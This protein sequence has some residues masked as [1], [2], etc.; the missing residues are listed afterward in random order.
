MPPIPPAPIS[1]PC[2]TTR[3]P[4]RGWHRV[5]PDMQGGNALQQDH[6]ASFVLLL[7]ACSTLEMLFAEL[8]LEGESGR[9]AG[10]WHPRGAHGTRQV[11]SYWASGQGLAGLLLLG[12]NL[13]PSHLFSF[14]LESRAADNAVAA[15][16]FKG[17]RPDKQ[18]GLPGISAA[19]LSQGGKAPGALE[20]AV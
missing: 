20:Q 15:P 14:A 9:A 11:K 3:S 8:P 4:H 1:S 18:A 19:G 2:Y 5:P 12:R 16:S 10:G 7:Q 6:N 17:Q 13:P